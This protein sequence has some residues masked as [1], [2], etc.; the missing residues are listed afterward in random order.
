MDLWKGRT[1]CRN[2]VETNRNT[3]HIGARDIKDVCGEIIGLK[4]ER[5]PRSETPRGV[6]ESQEERMKKQKTNPKLKEAIIMLILSTTS[7]I[8]GIAGVI[9]SLIC[10]LS[11]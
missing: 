7:F 4:R 3:Q 1:E 5:R 2:Y 9:I 10:M 11:S 6:T 8:L